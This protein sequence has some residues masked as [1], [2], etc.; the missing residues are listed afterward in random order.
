MTRR[1]AAVAALA[2][3]AFCFNT[4]ENLPIGLLRFIAADLDTSPSA[5]G[6]LVTG[7][8]IVVA[9]VSVPI[10]RLTVRVPR[11]P[12][13]SGVLL[14]L[15]LMTWAAALAPGYGPL[16]A[17]R[18]VTALGQALF[19]PVAV[20]TAAGLMPPERRGRAASYVFAGG[21][22]AIVLGVPAGTWLGEAAGWR[23]AFGALG[24]LALGALAAV[25]ALLPDGPPGQGHAAAATRPDARRFRLLIVVVVLA[26]GGFFT[27][28]TYIAEFLTEVTGVPEPALSPLL[29]ANG[30]ADVA[31]LAVAAALVDRGSRRLLGG[32]AAVMAVALLGL[33][34]FGAAP[35]GAVAGLVLM[36]LAIPAIATGM[37]ARVLETA[38]GNT[39]VAS[40]WASAAFNVGIAGG[41]LGG[42]LL[43]PV[44][45]VRATALAGALAVAAAAVLVGAE[46]LL[47][48]P[49]R[50]REPGRAPPGGEPSRR[51]VPG[52]PPGPG[53]RSGRGAG[54]GRRS[55]THSVSPKGTEPPGGQDH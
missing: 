14:V 42:G 19:W 17:V 2:V 54:R 13:L 20:V 10:T 37:Q 23:A 8:G 5:V 28:Y 46:R 35:A 36:G 15:V 4:T 33:F 39:D 30:A 43:L 53:R 45:G 27:A 34:A 49:G 1:G 44:Y 7:Y 25:A 52:L 31:G 21:S 51:A 29:L 22:L 12:L 16:L 6:L 38:P 3:A 9:A 48:R 41:A 24:V 40:A 26:V 47:A 55:E 18:V 11:R 32:A 50:P